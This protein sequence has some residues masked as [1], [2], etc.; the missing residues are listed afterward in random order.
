MAEVDAG[1]ATLD[2]AIEEKKAAKNKSAEREKLIAE[3]TVAVQMATRGTQT[4]R[5]SAAT[6]AK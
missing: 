5:M 2:L 1:V 4:S 3:A 6:A